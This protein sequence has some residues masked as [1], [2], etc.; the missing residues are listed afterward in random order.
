MGSPAVSLSGEQGN[1]RQI[2]KS[3]E[4]VE[5]LAGPHRISFHPPRH[6]IKR[7]VGG[8]SV[9]ARPTSTRHHQHK[10]TA[11]KCSYTGAPRKH[12]NNRAPSRDP[13]ELRRDQ[14]GNDTRGIPEFKITS[15]QRKRTWAHGS[16]RR[17]RCLVV[18]AGLEATEEEEMLQ[19]NTDCEET[20]KFL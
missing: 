14:S 7:L 13:R 1:S 16:A 3:D 20:P 17:R 8:L 5:H 11:L 15:S 4:S 10:S 12:N 6:N 18:S 2:S 9:D 19:S